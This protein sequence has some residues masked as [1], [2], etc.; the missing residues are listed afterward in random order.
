MLPLSPRHTHTHTLALSL[1]HT[2]WSYGVYRS[3]QAFPESPCVT[4]LG[5][6]CPQVVPKSK[7]SLEI[8]QSADRGRQNETQSEEAEKSLKEES[9]RFE[10]LFYYTD[11]SLG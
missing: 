9:T 2:H 6:L 7:L 8:M 1:T 4:A 11:Y 3:G 5:C 10:C